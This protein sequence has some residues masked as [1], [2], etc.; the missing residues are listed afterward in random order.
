MSGTVN[1][2]YSHLILFE[3]E[4][5]QQAPFKMF[6]VELVPEIKEEW[7][8]KKLTFDA[9]KRVFKAECMPDAEVSLFMKVET[10]KQY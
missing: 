3:W 5:D 1:Y 10:G 7:L 4:P 9:R 8:K 2:T 6:P